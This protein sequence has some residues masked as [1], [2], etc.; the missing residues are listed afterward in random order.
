MGSNDS[1]F[2][3]VFGSKIDDKGVMLI[4][5]HVHTS[6]SA[7]GHMS[8]DQIVEQAKVSGLDGVCITDHQTMAAGRQIHEGMQPN[9]IVVIIG[10]EYSTAQGDFLIFGPFETLPRD[11]PADRLL[12]SVKQSGGA[13]IAAHPFRQGRAV[14]EDLIRSGLCR[15]V[16]FYNG[17]N[18]MRENLAVSRWKKYDLIQCGGSDAHTLEELGAMGT[19]FETPVRSRSDLVRAVNSGLCSPELSMA[20]QISCSPDIRSSALSAPL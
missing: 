7:C 11:L 9:G 15:A 20:E 10:M 1:Y 6:F 8:V 5:L 12:R 4:D 3:F 17:R 13:A 18:A 19:R 2:E 16:E 14:D